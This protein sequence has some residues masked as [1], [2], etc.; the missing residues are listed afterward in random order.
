MQAKKIVR[1]LSEEEMIQLVRNAL[2][3]AGNKMGAAGDH[4]PVI[5]STIRSIM[6]DWE[7]L[8][9]ARAIHEE[10][11]RHLYTQ[12]EAMER[13]LPDCP[14]DVQE[15]VK[16]KLKELREICDAYFSEMDPKS[17][18]IEDFELPIHVLRTEVILDRLEM[19]NA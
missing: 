12:L 11:K 18:Y 2:I 15:N 5:K 9:I 14:P 3:V 8:K 7:N 6:K 10:M 19:E 16:P 17:F 13:V 4:W 1:D